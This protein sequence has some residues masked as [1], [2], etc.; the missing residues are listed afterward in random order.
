MNNDVIVE[1]RGLTKEFPGVKALKGVDFDIKR[2]SVHCVVGENGAGKSTFIKILTGAHRRTGGSL[3]YNGKD[4]DPKSIREAMDNGISVLYQELNVV[5]D[6]T[7]EENLTLGKE[8]TKW[9]FIRKSEGLNKT[10]DIIRSL[11]DSIELDMPVDQL[12]VAQKQVIE[13]AKALSTDCSVLVM[14]EPTASLSEDEVRRLFLTVKK[15]KEQGIT[16][17]FISHK[18]SEI[19]EIGDYVTVFRDGEMIGTKSVPEIAG[20]DDAAGCPDTFDD[21]TVAEACTELV[22]MMIGKVIVQEYVPSTSDYS[23]KLLEVK[24]V[25]NRRLKNINFEL[26]KGEILG[27][28][29]LVGAGKT[30]VGRVLYGI[31]DYEGEIS[32]NGKKAEY[33]N[34]IGALD[35]GLAMVPEERRVDGIFGQL[36]IRANIPLMRMDSVMNSGLI[37]RIKENRLADKFMNMMSVAAK[38]REQAVA[39]LSGGNQ[40]KVVIAKC[41]NRDADIIM[42][43]EPTRGVDVGAKEEIHEIIRDLANE[44]KSIIVFSSE[45]PEITNLCDRIVLMH[46]GNV[47]EIMKNQ[48]DVD[49]DHIMSVVAGG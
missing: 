11:D 41:L 3:K 42:L 43:D 34:V 25:N 14:D 32:V 48:K 21:A 31:D 20:Y 35:A 30:E 13:I 7:T 46:D 49:V 39:F 19:F 8:N 15:L 23:T 6:L 28:Y 18:L 44:G 22:R 38:D 45:L 4:F 26:Y 40:Q 27:F 33:K 29:G 2:G 9:G 12:S 47:G 16:I 5:D 10:M 17:V 1:V 36:S 24:N 37:S